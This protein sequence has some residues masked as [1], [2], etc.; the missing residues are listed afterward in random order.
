M[1]NCLMRDANYVLDGLLYQDALPIEEHSTYTA[2]YTDL[3]FGLFQVL[4]FR[5]APCLR[6]LPDQVLYQA[7]KGDHYGALNSFLQRSIREMLIATQWDDINRLT[8]S[9]KDA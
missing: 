8:A 6:D 7:E 5:S 9:L 3:V 1:V 4:G 2:G